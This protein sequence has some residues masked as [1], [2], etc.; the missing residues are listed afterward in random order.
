MCKSKERKL[1]VLNIVTLTV[2]LILFIGFLAVVGVGINSRFGKGNGFIETIPAPAI[3]VADNAELVGAADTVTVASG[4]NFRLAPMLLVAT[5]NTLT[6]TATVTP[7]TAANKKVDWSLAWV[8]PASAWA[9]GKIVTN[10]VTVTP[11]SDGAL[12]ATLTKV[13]DFGEQIRVTCKSRE[14]AAVSATATV[15]LRK[16]LTAQTLV[17][18]APS[19]TDFTLSAAQGAPTTVSPPTTATAYA[20]NVGQTVSTGTLDD[21]Y[22][23]T[24]KLFWNDSLIDIID[25][26]YCETLYHAWHET[27]TAGWDGKAVGTALTFNDTLMTSMFSTY[28]WTN[29]AAYNALVAALNAA[30]WQFRIQVVATGAYSTLTTNFY[31]KLPSAFFVV[32]PTNIGLNDT[33]FVF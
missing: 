3:E 20:V 31:F 9:T 15:D 25:Y 33:A 28:M 26:E 17:L 18:D 14:D 23:V 32:K 8:N 13:T 10:Y 16:K 12:T 1:G 27:P 2:A 7:V 11:A 6:I 4:S 19:G 21:T 5:G 29:A 24:K 22:T 30:G